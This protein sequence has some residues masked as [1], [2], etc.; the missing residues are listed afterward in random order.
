MRRE[1]WKNISSCFSVYNPIDDRYGIDTPYWKVEEIISLFNA[2]FQNNYSP[3]RFV[4][5]DEQCIRNNHRTAL[6]HTRMPKSYIQEGIRMEALTS[7]RGVMISCMIDFPGI[8][9]LD[10]TL[11]LIKN[12]SHTGH[13]IFMDRL[14][15]SYKVVQ[16]AKLEKQ[17]VVGTC[18]SDRGFSQ[19]LQESVCKLSPGQFEWQFK[20]GVYAYAWKDSAH[21]QLL[22]SF[23]LPESSSVW[24]RAPGLKEKLE[25]PA[26]SSFVDYNLGMGGN[27]VGDMLRSGISTHSKSKKWWKGIFFYLLDQTLIAS[28]RI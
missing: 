23:H 14:Y 17:Y 21:C 2:K 22:S 12:L 9:H 27:D 19:D 1:R 4:S 13:V 15:T 26:P 5:R 7:T 28:F 10:Q 20:N 18:R 25:R 8:T 16:L 6:R 3:A 11:T 24:R